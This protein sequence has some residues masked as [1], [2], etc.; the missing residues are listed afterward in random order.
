MSEPLARSHPGTKFLS[1][2]GSVKLERKLFASKIHSETG[3][4]E[5]DTNSADE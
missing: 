5:N 1:N 3:M 2:S 4:R